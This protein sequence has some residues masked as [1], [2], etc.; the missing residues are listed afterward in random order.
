MHCVHTAFGSSQQTEISQGTNACLLIKKISW[1]L[2]TEFNQILHA[3]R[4]KAF[5]S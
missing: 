2:K 4:I 3:Q 5:D 1:N